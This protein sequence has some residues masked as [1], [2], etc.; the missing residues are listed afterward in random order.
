[1]AAAYGSGRVSYNQ[2]SLSC[3]VQQR[4]LQPCATCSPVPPAAL[5][6]LQLCAPCSSVP[7]AALCPLQPCATCSSVPPACASLQLRLRA[8]LWPLSS[9]LLSCFFAVHV[10]LPVFLEAF[11]CELVLSVL[12]FNFFLSFCIL[13]SWN[14]DDIACA[15]QYVCARPGLDGLWQPFFSVSFADTHSGPTLNSIVTLW[16]PLSHSWLLPQDEPGM[17][18]LW[19]A[20]LHLS[21]SGLPPS[22]VWRGM[23]FL[24]G[25]CSSAFLCPLLTP[26]V[27]GRHLQLPRLPSVH[28]KPITPYR[29]YFLD[30]IF[31]FFLPFCSHTTSCYMPLKS[32]S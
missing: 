5:C 27:K 24:Q 7:P 4:P 14:T 12:G 1:V 18:R 2:F 32:F 10:F 15:S 13:E 21:F 17:L 6:P 23:H 30:T 26:S 3:L 19:T 22:S 16:T 20:H 29:F 9:L 25:P 31:N 8:G 28:V 11:L